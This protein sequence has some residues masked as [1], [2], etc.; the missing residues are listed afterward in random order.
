[1]FKPKELFNL[2][3]TKFAAI[4]HGNEYAWEA[5]PKINEYISNHIKPKK[6][7]HGMGSII[8]EGEVE[9]GEGT[10]IE[11]NVYIKGPAIIGKN[12][13]IRQSA[14]IR[15]NVLIGDHCII[16]NSTEIKN[17]ILFNSVT[18]PHFNYIGDS[19]L[20]YKVHL[21][22]GVILSNVKTPPREIQVITLEK[23][24][25]TGLL[26]FGAL[27][28]DNTEIGCNAVLSPG[29]VLGQHCL[30]YPG[31]IFRG[32]APDNAIIKLRQEQEIVIKLSTN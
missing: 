26:K 21:G 10:V 3:Q 30:V 5:I 28:G 12:C 23:R 15:G 27:I 19:I 16:G 31:V 8:I 17:S 13:I 18:V 14:Y 9:I 32:V 6:E 25:D 22:A 11:P 7:A 24:Y 20:G 2:E 29:T 4:F 1:M